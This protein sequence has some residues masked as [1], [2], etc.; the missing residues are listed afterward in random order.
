VLEELLLETDLRI[1]ILDPNSDYVGLAEARP[2]AS[3]DAAA[4]WRDV[5]GRILVRRA[6]ATADDRLSLR[7]FDLGT[8]L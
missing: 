4:R 2:D 7:F 6:T 1:V 5:A 3:P 8:S